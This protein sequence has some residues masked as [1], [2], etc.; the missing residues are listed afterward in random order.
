MEGPY[1]QAAG[2]VSKVRAMMVWR[3]VVSVEGSKVKK[4]YQLPDS[5]HV[6]RSCD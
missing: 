1:I 3:V 5:E 6:K 4:A 2:H